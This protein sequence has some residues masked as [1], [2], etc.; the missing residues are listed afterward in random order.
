VGRGGA[1]AAAAREYDDDDD[2]DARVETASPAS[3]RGAACVVLRRGRRR[4]QHMYAS[5]LAIRQRGARHRDGRSSARVSGGARGNSRR[6]SWY[7]RC[8]ALAG[9]VA[10]HFAAR[11]RERATAP[12]RGACAFGGRLARTRWRRRRRRR[13]R[14][15]KAQRTGKRASR[16][17]P[18]RATQRAPHAVTAGATTPPAHARRATTRRGAAQP[19]DALVITPAITMPCPANTKPFS[20]RAAPRRRPPAA[21]PLTHAACSGGVSHCSPA[22]V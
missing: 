2:D 15:E 21:A 6:A 5:A 1:E 22:A 7:A 8:G 4:T 19:H 14:D 16:C 13:R 9:R 18:L 17:T 10:L 11:G 20:G 12:R 3:H